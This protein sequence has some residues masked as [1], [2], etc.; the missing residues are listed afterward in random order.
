[1]FFTNPLLVIAFVY[2]IYNMNFVGKTY[3]ENIQCSTQAIRTLS[4]QRTLFYL[5]LY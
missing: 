1:M 2:A 5:A 4:S 3:I